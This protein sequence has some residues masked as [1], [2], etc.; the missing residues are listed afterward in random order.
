MIPSNPI[1]FLWYLWEYLVRVE[2]LVVHVAQKYIEHAMQI[3]FVNVY[4]SEH[5]LQVVEFE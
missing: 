2:T 4:P 3:P 1:H 5:L